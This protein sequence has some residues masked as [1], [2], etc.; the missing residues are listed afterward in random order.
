MEEGEK[1]DELQV[2]VATF[3]AP[4]LDLVTFQKGNRVRGS[5][6]IK[7]SNNETGTLQ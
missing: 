7:F 5:C 4:G 6:T 2:E 3:K 1:W